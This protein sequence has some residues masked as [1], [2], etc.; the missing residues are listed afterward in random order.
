[1][2]AVEITENPNAVM[3]YVNYEEAIVQRYS[4]VLEG[5]TFARFVNPSKLS[6]ALPP[7]QKLLNALNDGSC[8]FVK[9]TREQRKACKKEYCEKVVTREIQVPEQKTRKD[10]GQKRKRKVSKSTGDTV[11]DET[12]GSSDDEVNRKK[13][14]HAAKSK[15]T[16]ETSDEDD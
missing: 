12:S 15:P 14:H 5:W 16:V 8:K 1:V 7:L 11:D 6:T 9:L 10:A 4:I 3:Q 13:H 2:L